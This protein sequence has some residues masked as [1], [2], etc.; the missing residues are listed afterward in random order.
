MAITLVVLLRR[1]SAE[2]PKASP[3]EVAGLVHQVQPFK[4][5]KGTEIIRG[6]FGV[7]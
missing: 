6:A 5:G 2:I 3:P 4:G 1:L 7:R